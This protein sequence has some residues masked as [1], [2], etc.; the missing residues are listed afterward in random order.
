MPQG[1]NPPMLQGVQSPNVRID[2]A[3]FYKATRRMRFPMLSSKAIQGLGTSDNV[4]LKKTGVVAELEIRLGGQVVIGG[5]IG[6]TTMS[7]SWPYDLVQKFK[8]SA[9]GQSNLHDARGSEYKAMEYLID[10]PLSDRGVSQRYGN[11]TAVNQGTLSLS[12]ED[13]GGTGAASNY[14][15]PGLNVAAIGTYPINLTYKIPVC[16]DPVTLVGSVYGQSQA[17]NLNLEIVWATQAQLFSAVGASA[18][19]DFSGVTVDVTGVVYSIPNVNGQYVVPDLSQFHQIVSQP[20]AAA[21]AGALEYPI[22]GTGPGRFWLRSLFQAWSNSVPLVMNDTNFADL[23][24]KYGGNDTPETVAKGSKLRAI[25]ERQARVDLGKNWGFG[26]WDFASQNALRDVVD[27]GATSDL[28]L[29]INQVSSPTAGQVWI[30][31]EFL[32]SGVVG[33]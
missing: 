9:N 3:T 14:M 11:A 20:S 6:T 29:V 16:A 2:P 18:T 13:W 25:N 15:A 27:T 1:A 33:A 24:W 22:T 31:N 26:V 17:T 30:C 21:S 4:Q 28:R 23:A 32:F 5:T 12:H 19:V 7:Y 10:G 8:L